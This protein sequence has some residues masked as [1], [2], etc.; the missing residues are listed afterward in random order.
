MREEI[1][2]KFKDYNKELEKILEQKD[3]EED[4]KNLLLSMFYK[5]ETSYNDYYIVKRKSKTKQEYLENILNNIRNCN[6]IKLIKPTDVEF[7]VFKENGLYEIDLKLGKIKAIANEIVLLSAI[8]EINNFQIR[9]NEKYNLIR[10][11]MPYLLNMAYDMENIEVLRD[12]NAWSWNILTSEMKDIRIN[13]VYQILKIALNFDLFQIMQEE[14]N[15]KDVMEFVTEEL[16]KEY[17]EKVTN[18]LIEYISKIAIMIYITISENERK[19]LQEEK[20]VIEHELLE[21]KDKKLYIDKITQEKKILKNELKKIDLII[22]NKALL[23]EEFENRNQQL[24]EYKQFFSISHLVEKMQ[25]ERKKILE[26]IESCNHKMEP[27]NYIRDKQYLQNEYHLLKDIYFEKENNVYHVINQ[28]QV[29]F[30]K[31]ILPIRIEHAENKSELI[32]LVYELRYYLFLPY[33]ENEM[34]KTKKEFQTHIQI[35]KEKIIKKL[36]EKKWINTLSS[37]EENDIMIISSLFNLKTINLDNI[38]FHI[39]KPKEK[40]LISIY[41]EKDTLEDTLEMNLEFQKKDK[42]KLN[43]KIKLF[44]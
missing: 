40:Y 28:L 29:L 21:I 18:K 20:E 27:N 43:R 11:S 16:Q 3:F 6:Q 24:P 4:T 42:I 23:L 13:L 22:N 34:V 19:R 37:N 14:N 5:L 30:L 15:Y 39:S 32:D 12:F 33:T 36:L 8:L 1:F 17:S 7:N 41:D 2:S 25:K 26:K 9:L 31:E 38:Y 44:I 35:I 10:N